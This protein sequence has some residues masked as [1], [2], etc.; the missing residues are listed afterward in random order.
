MDMVWEDKDATW[1]GIRKLLAA[2]AG[3]GEDPGWLVFPEMTLT[4]F[5]M[6]PEAASLNPQDVER[7]AE[8]ARA[9]HAWVTFGGVREGRNELIT[10]SPAGDEV[11]TY[12]KLHLYGPGREPEHYVAGQRREHFE[13]DGLRVVPAICYDLRFPDVFWGAAL[14]TDVY[15]LIANWPARR[16]LH[17]R[18]LLRARAIENQAYVIGVNRTGR[19][20]YVRYGG[21]SCVYGPQGEALLECDNEPGLYVCPHEL[22]AARV[23]RVRRH[24]PF[25]KDRKEL[26]PW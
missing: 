14:S 6:R 1:A 22:D 9:E 10:L 4:G 26:P 25:L 16:S 20:P 17:F 24:F 23:E 18:T 3:R 11:S 13:L 15:V 21:A 5:S 12:A 7:F 2:S 8:L 19:D